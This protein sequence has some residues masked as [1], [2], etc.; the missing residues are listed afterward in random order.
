MI[1]GG[2]G[3]MRKLGKGGSRGVHVGPKKFP[4]DGRYLLPRK[5]PSTI[6]GNWGKHELPLVV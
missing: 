4:I 3:K 5:I 6:L 1:S 2:Q